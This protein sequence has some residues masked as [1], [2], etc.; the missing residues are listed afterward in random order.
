M[1]IISLNIHRSQQ[2]VIVSYY[3]SV[4]FLASI[5]ME[6]GLSIFTQA[7]SNEP[8]SAMVWTILSKWSK[9][10][11]KRFCLFFWSLCHNA[12][13]VKFTKIYPKLNILLNSPNNLRKIKFGEVLLKQGKNWFICS[14][15]VKGN[16]HH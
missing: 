10:K 1:P 16:G 14:A 3:F 9:I 2:F 6:N 8:F 7:I 13:I 11:R 12:Y 4:I 5:C 15:S